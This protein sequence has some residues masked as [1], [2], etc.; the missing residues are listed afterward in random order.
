MYS[1][2]H[3]Q[4]MLLTREFSRG[5][6]GNPRG[7]GGAE[8]RAMVTIPE[9]NE[10]FGAW[11][12]AQGDLHSGLDGRPSADSERDA[13][14]ASRGELG[15]PAGQVELRQRI[16]PLMN[17]GQILGVL[18]D[19][20]SDFVVGVTQV[21]SPALRRTVNV[22]VPIYVLYTHSLAFDQSRAWRGSPHHEMLLGSFYVGCGHPID[23]SECRVHH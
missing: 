15:Q 14:Q 10:L 16:E 18:I 7:A 17:V 12:V 13:V 4:E 2:K 3:G 23:F 21:Q 9:S 19:D 6:G 20:L 1:V 5:A 11:S 22:A 8:H